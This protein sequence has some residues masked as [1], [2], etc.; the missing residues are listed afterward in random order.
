[1]VSSY[2]VEMNCVKVLVLA[3]CLCSSQP[4]IHFSKGEMITIIAWHVARQIPMQT[5]ILNIRDQFGNGSFSDRHIRYVYNEFSSG[6]RTTCDRREGSGAPDSA[7]NADTEERA[8]RLLDASRQWTVL[9]LS[10]ELG[11]STGSVSNLMREMG[12]S[13]VASK[14]VPYMITEK[15]RK[16]RVRIAMENYDRYVTDPGIID[17]VIAIDE[18]ILRN[19]QAQDADQ[20][21]EWRR[22]DEA[23]PVRAHQSSSG[24]WWV[25]MI[26]A[27]HRDKILAWEYLG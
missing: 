3:F 17:R 4:D 6:S 8:E 22:A 23:R 19:Y 20:A 25:L 18:M 26:V 7:V 13:K 14:W 27:V 1:M 2:S 24:R 5:T 11:I 15:I 16:R 12:Y 21:R 9:E 10:D